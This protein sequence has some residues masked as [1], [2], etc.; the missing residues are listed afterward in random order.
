MVYYP[1]TSLASHWSAVLGR[2]PVFGHGAIYDYA[3]LFKEL[4]F[5]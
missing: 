4:L 2:K 5:P 1:A 3:V